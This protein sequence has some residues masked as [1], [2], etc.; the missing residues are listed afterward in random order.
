M[1]PAAVDLSVLV[2]V[3]EIDQQLG[4]GG[5]LETLGVPTAAGSSSTGEHG[6]VSAADLPATLQSEE[7]QREGMDGFNVSLKP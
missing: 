4:A 3:D 6:D 1:V 7:E 2:E 5:A